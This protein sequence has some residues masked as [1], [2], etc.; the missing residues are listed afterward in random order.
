[1]RQRV[2]IRFSVAGDL[3][4]L[5]HSDMVR[6]F[7]RAVARAGLS[8]RYTEGFNPRPRLWLPL[9]RSVAV[10]SEDEVLVLELD[11]PEPPERVLRRLEAHAVAGMKLRDAMEIHPSGLPRPTE[12]TYQLDLEALEQDGAPREEGRGNATFSDEDTGPLEQLT[13]RT[14]LEDRIREITQAQRIE[15][16][17]RT[18]KRGNRRTVDIRPWIRR[19]ALSHQTLIADVTI[20][21]EGSARP[22]ELLT[23]LGFEPETALPHLQRTR[24]H[25]E[26]LSPPPHASTNTA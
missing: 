13:Q 22:V 26:G 18:D 25:W 20:S 19:I 8:I 14:I 2:A 17:R 5:A 1:M 10:A 15:V 6:H 11:P 3:R 7:E 16:Q 24:V 21:P 4:F 12:A 23:V 9:P